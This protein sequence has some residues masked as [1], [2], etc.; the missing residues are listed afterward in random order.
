MICAAVHGQ[1][2]FETNIVSVVDAPFPLSRAFAYAKEEQMDM[3]HDAHAL[4]HAMIV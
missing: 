2:A 3:L 4:E 1:T